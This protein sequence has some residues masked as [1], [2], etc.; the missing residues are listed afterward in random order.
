MAM[1]VAAG[2]ETDVCLAR[3]GREGRWRE[4]RHYEQGT[5][6]SDFGLISPM[7]LGIMHFSDFL[8][9]THYDP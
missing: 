2:A 5:E 1:C 3:G 4:G 6:S 8:A 9:K 7:V